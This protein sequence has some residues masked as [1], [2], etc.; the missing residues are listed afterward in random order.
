MHNLTDISGKSG[1][2]PDDNG[3]SDD[4]GRMSGWMQK[5]LTRQ[6]SAFLSCVRDVLEHLRLVVLLWSFRSVV[7]AVAA[8]S[9]WATVI[10]AWTS[11]AFTTWSAVVAAVVVTT[12]TSVSAW[13]ALRLDIALRLLDESLA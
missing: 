10:A 1:T 9:S 13:L 6:R 4:M 5:R 12:W 3:K 8:R 2:F 11:V 7:A